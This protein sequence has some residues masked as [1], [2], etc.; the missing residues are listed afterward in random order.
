M[1]EGRCRL[2]AAPLEHVFVDLG[3]CPLANSFLASEQL[4]TSE[5]SYPLRAFVCERC[6]LVQLEEYAAPEAIFR[7]YAY[8]SSYS[9]SWLAHARAYVDEVV[10]RFGLDGG[11]QVIEIG[12]N[13]GYLLRNFVARGIPALGIDPAANVARAA[14]RRGVPTLV[15]FF[16]TRVARALRVDSRADLLIANNVLAHV[17][18]LHDFVA[19]MRLLLAPGGIVTVEHP[20]LLALI[21]GGQ[22]DTI[23]HEHFSYFSF[24]TAKAVLEQHGLRVFDVEELPTH[25]GSLRL[26]ACHVDDARQQ[27]PSV[28][29]MVACERAAK[30]DRLT[31]YDEFAGRVAADKRAILALLRDLKRD[32]CAIAAYGAPAKGNTLLNYCGIGT[33]LIDYT[34]DLNPHKQGCFLPGSRIPIYPPEAIR[35]R[36]PDV[37]FILP[38]N[39]RD[40]IVAQLAH[41][42]DW[43]GRF[44]VRAPELQLVV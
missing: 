23:Y 39:L 31:T 40:E 20:H 12:S 5:P 29:A 7:D 18:D 26:Y 21:E 37:V 4:A 6:L 43:G 19:G 13:D 41:V 16:G 17:S 35:E 1:A 8:Y 22:F 32:G 11:T 33:D 42:R 14:V 28:D 2:C 30:L 3:N 44:A 10:A 36:R 38:W 25:G 9:S 15:E 27:E 34:V 24:S